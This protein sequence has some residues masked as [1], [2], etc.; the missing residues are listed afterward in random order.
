MIS[1]RQLAND[2]LFAMQHKRFSPSMDEKIALIRV[3]GLFLVY[4]E[5]DHE[6]ASSNRMFS[7]YVPFISGE[8]CSLLEKIQTLAIF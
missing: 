4:N 8:K 1:S 3:E 5:S 6:D 7:H 2:Q